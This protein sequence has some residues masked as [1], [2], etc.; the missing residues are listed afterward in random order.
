[1]TDR[2]TVQRSINAQSAPTAPVF[3]TAAVVASCVGFVL[4]GV[5]QA[6]YGPAIPAF[7]E[8][9]GL[10]PSAAGLG[11]SARGPRAPQCRYG[12]RGTDHFER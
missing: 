3:S 12:Q 10:S 7:R 5:L 1:M 8:E 11:L 2:S 6:L 9:F 4:I